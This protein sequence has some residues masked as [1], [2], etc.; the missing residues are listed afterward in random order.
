MRK[1]LSASLLAF[2]LAVAPVAAHADSVTYNLILTPTNPASNVGSGTG[3]LTVNTAPSASGNSDFST[4][5][6][7]LTA[8]SFSIGG[9]TFD[10]TNAVG[11]YGD[12]FFQNGNLISVVYN[13]GTDNKSVDFSLLAG[14]LTYTFADFD[15]FGTNGQLEFSQGIISATIDPPGAPAVP[16]PSALLLF[17]TGALGLAGIVSRKLS[18]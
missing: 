12:A 18:A 1:L 10:L 9:D 17:G 8:L 6:G 3:S 14:A 11:N 4:I 13:G 5:N 16:E 2:G 15:N 7:G